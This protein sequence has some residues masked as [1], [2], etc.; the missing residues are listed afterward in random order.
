MTPE[1]KFGIP[2]EAWKKILAVIRQTAPESE[3]ILYGSRAKGNYKPGSDIDLC[4]KWTSL[5]N[6]DL[7]IINIA[8]EDLD[9]PWEIDLALYQTVSNPMLL[10]HIDRVGIS[11]NDL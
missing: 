5:T 10:E 9:L 3:V 8:L 2:C 7:Q 4:L 6:S 11:I 1:S